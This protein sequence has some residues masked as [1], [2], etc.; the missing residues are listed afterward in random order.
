MAET[1][2]GE[3][4]V[5]PLT[6]ELLA[7]LMRFKGEGDQEDIFVFASERQPEQ[8]Y[9]FRK[10]WVKARETAKLT[11]FRFHDLRHTAASLLAMRGATLLQIAD[12]LGHKDTVV[13]KRYAHLCVDHKQ[14]L[15]D[16]VMGGMLE[17]NDGR[18]EAS[19]RS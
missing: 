3:P 18:Q 1:K 10:H 2:N 19:G 11:D 7:E 8:P 9:D 13:T 6:E 16:Q 15:I 4:R 12:V 14:Q 17:S 5:L